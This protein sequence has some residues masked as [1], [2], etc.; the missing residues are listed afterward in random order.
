M[1]EFINRTAG[2]AT[3]GDPVVS[4]VDLQML[5]DYLRAEAD[6]PI[7][8]MLGKQATSMAIDFLGYDLTPRDWTLKHWEWPTIG[9]MTSPT[10]SGQ[11]G[12]YRREIRLPYG[13][14]VSVQSVSLYGENHTDFTVRRDS[15]VLP[16]VRVKAQP[17]DEPAIVVEYT[18]GFDPVPEG[19]S[20]AVLQL[21]AF[22]YH[23]RGCGL[24]DALTGSGARQ[25]LQPWQSPSKVVL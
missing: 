1:S 17:A 9:T 14:I 3:T 19:I 5:A 23:N 22:L 24:A 13:R 12:Y 8:P 21:A 15:I 6:D 7:L 4:V 2:E 11:Q 25:A 10:L 20:D 18:A 16:S